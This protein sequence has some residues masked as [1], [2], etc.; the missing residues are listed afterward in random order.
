[1]IDVVIDILEAG[2]DTLLV[3]VADSL[4]LPE[5]E[6][7]VYI[8]AVELKGALELNEPPYRPAE[9]DFDKEAVEVCAELGLPAPPEPN[10]LADAEYVGDQ[11]IDEIEGSLGFAVFEVERRLVVELMADEADKLL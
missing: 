6:D 3:L 2:D 10:E 1:M 9:D 11:I 7:V 5:T 4:G 8:E